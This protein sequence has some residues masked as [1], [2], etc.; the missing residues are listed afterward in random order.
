[1]SIGK[2][3]RSAVGGG[4]ER[5]GE[6]TGEL[7]GNYAVRGMQGLWRASVDIGVGMTQE[8]R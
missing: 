5:A 7:T 8:P 6:A 3:S 1:M 4:Y 2:G